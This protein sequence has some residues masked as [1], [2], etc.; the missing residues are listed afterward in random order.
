MDTQMH[1]QKVKNVPHKESARDGGKNKTSI[2]EK[3]PG[4]I[5]HRNKQKRTVRLTKRNKTVR[6]IF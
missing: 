1:K 6:D 4:K 3:Q 5:Y 2:K